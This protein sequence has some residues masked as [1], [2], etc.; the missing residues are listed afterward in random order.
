MSL[1][2]S[3]TKFINDRK[4]IKL[5]VHKTII[6]VGFLVIISFNSFS[7]KEE[8]RVNVSSLSIDSLK[9]L[10]PL[11]SIKQKSNAIKSEVKFKLDTIKLAEG[12]I[13]EATQIPQSKTDSIVTKINS[14]I[15][16]T[17]QK[18]LH[19]FD[20]V[21]QAIT[22]KVS[23]LERK[24]M[25]PI[26]SIRL[27]VNTK[28]QSAQGKLTNPIDSIQ[29]SINKTIGTFRDNGSSLV[30]QEAYLPGL[31][32]ANTKKLDGLQLPAT[33]VPDLSDNQ[34][35]KVDVKGGETLGEIKLPQTDFPNLS[36]EKLKEM[37]ELEE[38]A[39]VKSQIGM[40]ETKLIQVEGYTTDLQKISEGN[41]DEVKELPKELEKQALKL[42]GVKEFQGQSEKFTATQKSYEALLQKYKDKKLLQEEM[43]SKSI[44]LANDVVNKDM[45]GVQEA[46]KKMAKAKK[47]YGNFKS[48]NDLPKKRANEMRGKSFYQRLVPGFG[49]QIYQ[50]SKIIIDMAPQV[51]FRLTGRFTTGLAYVYRIGVDKHYKWLLNNQGIYGGRA[52]AQYNVI[53]SFFLQGEMEYLHITEKG[54]SNLVLSDDIKN[55]VLQTNLGVGK[56]FNLSPKL[57][58]NASAFYRIEWSGT[59][60]HQS[61]FNLRFGVDYI[62]TNVGRSKFKRIK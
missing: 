11:D 53:K 51:G 30:G 55:N 4:V 31:P 15:K 54:F 34:K 60:P 29:Q 58:G 18:I 22:G 39:K 26:D 25:S 45:P 44:T 5:T 6:I 23:Q 40:V 32:D 48:L 13:R 33:N 57:R 14:T 10:T 41:L 7:Q 27:Q 28:I 2:L 59:L 35:L 52:F 42:D 46:Q 19:P 21:Q 61:K 16:S 12:K 9:D 56:F 62:F 49:T 50:S 8:K 38:V 20:S 1:F 24:I 36:T 3:R 43:K 47:T 17:E 37:T